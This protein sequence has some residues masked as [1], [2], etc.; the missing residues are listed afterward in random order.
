MV[1]LGATVVSKREHLGSPIIDKETKQ[2]KLMGGVPQCY[3]TK[4][5]VT[6]QAMGL[7][8]ETEIT[9]TEYDAFQDLRKYLCEGRMGIVKKFGTE[10]VEPIFTKYTLI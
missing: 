2:Q 10:Y 3:P 7:E 1:V 6:L 4:Y 5:Y 8:L 9:V